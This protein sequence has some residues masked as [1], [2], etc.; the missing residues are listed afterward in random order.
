MTGGL[1]VATDWTATSAPR[2]AAVVDAAATNVPGE[3][4]DRPGIHHLIDIVWPHSL[5]VTGQHALQQPG[6]ANK[7]NVPE[8]VEVT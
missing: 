2:T 4:W 3:Y 6:D 7:G 8:L 1:A 5:E